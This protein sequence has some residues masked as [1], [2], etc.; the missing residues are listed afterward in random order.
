MGIK[1]VFFT[2]F[3]TKAPLFSYDECRRRV[4]SESKLRL[5]WGA[6]MQEWSVG[7]I[8]TVQ[9]WRQQS[10]QAL[11]WLNHNEEK[12]FQNTNSTSRYLYY[13]K[14]KSLSYLLIVFPFPS[15]GTYCNEKRNE[16][17][18]FL[19]ERFVNTVDF[20]GRADICSSWRGETENESDQSETKWS[21]T[22]V[23]WKQ[24]STA[25]YSSPNE[26]RHTEDDFHPQRLGHLGRLSLIALRN[27]A[28]W[29]HPWGIFSE[30]LKN[31]Q[32]VT[33]SQTNILPWPLMAGIHQQHN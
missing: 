12:S 5:G 2:A 25:Y 28:C 14:K 22:R 15:G 9:Q 10:H 4:R 21:V 24:H 6:D 30:S 1:N 17:G 8:L 29:S 3:E 27:G 32:W 31:N 23:C 16:G 7:L 18:L 19:T 20:T 26:G 11:K 13:R 33:S